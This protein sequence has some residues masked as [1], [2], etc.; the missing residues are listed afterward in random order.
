MPD[1]Q[2]NPNL[3]PNPQAGRVAV[4]A[5]G[6]DGG[7]IDEEYEDA[8]SGEE[9]QPHQ[10]ESVGMEGESQGVGRDLTLTPTP[11]PIPTPT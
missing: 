9:A 4:H 5:P 1:L 7:W 10:E 11:I 2:L 8:D 6:D 3:T